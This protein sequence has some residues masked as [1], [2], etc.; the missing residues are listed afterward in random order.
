MTFQPNQNLYG[1]GIGSTNGNGYYP[2][3][4]VRA[5][6]TSDTSYPI[7]TNWIYLGN[8]AYVLIGLTSTGGTL[9]A[10]WVETVTSTGSVLSVTGTTNQIT[11]TPT[12]GAVVL[13]IPSAFVAPGSVTAT[14]TLTAT[15]GNITAA[16]G[17]FVSSTAGN[18][19]VLNSGTASGTTT[20]TLNGRSGQI[21]ITTPSIA[22]GATFTFT[23]TNSSVTSS[24]TQ[25]MYNLVGGTTGAGIN[26]Q[27]VTNSAGSSVVVLMNSTGATTNTASII[28]TF[29]VLN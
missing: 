1:I 28:L 2:H 26:I 10:T 4:D 16:A 29:L 23:I 12:T 11:A 15:A 13:S 5:P 6:T 27:S 20:A 18:G 3:L 19:I 7:G 8:S 25:I 17:N 9:S 21:T 22:A 14:T 24:T